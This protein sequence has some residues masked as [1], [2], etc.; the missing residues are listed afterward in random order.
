MENKADVGGIHHTLVEV[1]KHSDLQNR[2]TILAMLRD[3][4]R[5]IG[6]R[7]IEHK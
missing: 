6:L 7:R 2:S 4:S 1:N 3:E 5:K